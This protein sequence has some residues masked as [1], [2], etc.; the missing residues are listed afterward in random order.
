MTGGKKAVCSK[1]ITGVR[2]QGKEK[3]DEEEHRL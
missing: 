1:K 3:N 2:A